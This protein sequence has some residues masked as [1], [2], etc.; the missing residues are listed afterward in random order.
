MEAELIATLS[1]TTMKMVHLEKRQFILTKLRQLTELVENNTI[2]K[3]QMIASYDGINGLLVEILMCYEEKKSPSD[4]LDKI[5]EMKIS[6]VDIDTILLRNVFKTIEDSDTVVPL[7][8]GL[9][10]CTQTVSELLTAIWKNEAASNKFIQDL[11]SE[12][13]KTHEFSIDLVQEL[14]YYA[15]KY[16]QKNTLQLLFLIQLAEIIKGA[17]KTEYS[18]QTVHRLLHFIPPSGGL[19]R[20]LQER[21]KIWTIQDIFPVVNAETYRHARKAAFGN[22]KQVFADF[23]CLKDF[24]LYKFYGPR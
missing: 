24:D 6:F 13:I 1:D 9:V 15:E 3:A 22:N 4:I 11:A 17:E 10:R 19:I 21:S 12:L 5:N 18:I 7:L 23:M 8:M 14:M 20:A 16:K 2:T